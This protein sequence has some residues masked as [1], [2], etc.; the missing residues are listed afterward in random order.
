MI[1]IY[2]DTEKY[3]FTRDWR[4]WGFNVAIYNAT[5]NIYYWIG[6]H[7]LGIKSI[8]TLTDEEQEELDV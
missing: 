2:L 6:Q 5:W 1:K 8:S 4:E 3:S 7:I